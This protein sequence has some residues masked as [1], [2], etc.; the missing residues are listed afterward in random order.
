[1]SENLNWA[2]LPEKPYKGL[3]LHF[4]C[5]SCDREGFTPITKIRK[6]SVNYDGLST[7]YTVEFTC[8]FCGYKNGE[9]R[10]IWYNIEHKGEVQGGGINHWKGFIK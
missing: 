7:C 1:M 3:K 9:I 4:T 6:K 8:L 5:I 10:P 2:E